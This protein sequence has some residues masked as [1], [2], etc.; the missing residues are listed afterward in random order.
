MKKISL[1]L[2]IA[3]F[4]TFASAD[5]LSVSA[6]VGGWS[7]DIDGYVKL[8]NTKNYFDKKS[9]QTD[10]NPNTGD[11]GLKTKTRPYF[12]IKLIHPLPVIPNVKF[13]YTRY[14]STGHSN[15]IAGNVKVFDIRINTALTDATTTQTIDSYDVTLFYEFKPVFADIE[16]GAGA[17]YWKG[18]TKIYGTDTTTH[19][20]KTWVDNSWTTVLP[21]VYGHIETMSLFGFSILGNVKWAKAGDNHHYDYVGAIKYTFDAPGPVNPFIKVGYRYKDAQGKDGDNITNIK[22]KGAFAEIG[23]KF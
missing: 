22:Y 23:A 3:G 20:S 8:G 4:F 14:D 1:A 13:Q 21:Y 15:Y 19:I 10:G 5:F 16:V 7:E 12:W 2:C 11:F 9:A 17:D 18:H 6:G